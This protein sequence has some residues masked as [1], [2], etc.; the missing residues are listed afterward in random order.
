MPTGNSSK[1]HPLF[2]DLTG[3]RFGRLVALSYVG[4]IKNTSTWLCRCDCGTEKNVSGPALRRG[5]STSCGCFRESIRSDLHHI[6][7]MTESV[8]YKTWTRMRSRCT[9]P[10]CRE[11]PHY[12]GRGITICERWEA[13]ENFYQ[14]MGPRPK[15]HSIDR[16]D[17]DGN[18]EPANCRWATVDQQLR[19]K[20]TVTKITL[21]GETL[22]LAEWAR[23]AG[24]CYGTVAHRIKRGWS[25]EDAITK[26]VRSLKAST[27]DAASRPKS[28]HA[29]C[30][31]Q[32][33]PPC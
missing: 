23:R 8:E 29:E 28:H 16:I 4:S 24:I 14:D 30:S 32:N 33:R 12:G 22:C 20:R 1:R 31:E 19:N 27:S 18:Y 11:W 25:A 7:G 3:K 21:N 9:S 26:P 13:F 17:N 6:H 5:T 10:T 15:G 2:K